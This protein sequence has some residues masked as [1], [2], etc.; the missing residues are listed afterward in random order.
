VVGFTIDYRGE[1]P[2][3]RKPAIREQHN[4]DVDDDNNNNNN[5][6]NLFMCLT[7]TIKAKYSQE[8]N[9]STRNIL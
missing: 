4:N 7:T 2:G 9:N 1:M 6:I 3:K 5:S 8:Q